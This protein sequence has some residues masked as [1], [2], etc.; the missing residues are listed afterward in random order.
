MA[1]L[2]RGISLQFAKIVVP[3]V[4]PPA[5]IITP[6][7]SPTLTPPKWHSQC[8]FQFLLAMILLNSKY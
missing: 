1:C 6:I 3:A 4:V 7:P 8:C 5:R 2:H